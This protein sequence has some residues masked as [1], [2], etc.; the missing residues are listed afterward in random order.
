MHI[1]GKEELYEIGKVI[2]AKQFMRYR[3]GEN[4][5]IENFEKRLTRKIGVNHAL[6]VNSGTSALICAMVGLGIG[7]GD[8]VIVPA[9]TWVATAYGPLGAGAI[10]VL[11]DVDESLMMDPADIERKITPHTRAI[12]PVHMSNLVCNMDAIMKI[13]RKHKLFVCEDACQAVGLTYKSK[14]VGTIGHANAFSFN[15]FKNITCGEGGAALTDDPVIYE[16]MRIYH[17]TGSYT[18]DAK[19]QVKIPF[20]V[21]QNYRASEIMGAMLGVQLDRLDPV[22]E[23]LKKRRKVLAEILSTSKQFKLGPH[24]D[25]DNAVALTIQFE[26]EKAARS[27]LNRHGDRV[28]IPLDSG[29]HVYTNWDPLIN[30]RVFHPKMNPFSWAKRKITYSKDMCEKSLEILGRTCFVPFAHNIPMSKLRALGKAL[31]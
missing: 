7:P 28:N 3:G 8:E 2:R 20:F 9:Y 18:R 5:F 23:N 31:V 21:G 4:G 1:M 25:L 19:T 17:D 15:Q 14:R 29:R 27:F 10:P 13:A 6:T 30:Q 12:I 26:S 22:L 24:N 16:R 11:A